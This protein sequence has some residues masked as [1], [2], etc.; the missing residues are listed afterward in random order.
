MSTWRSAR[1][2]FL[3]ALGIASFISIG[4]YGYGALRNHSA[5]YSYLIWNLLL[6]W[7]PLLFAILITRTLQ[8]KRWSSWQGIG[9]SI[10]WLVFLPNSFYMISDYIHL[11]EVKRVD[12]LFD[13]VMFTSFVYVGVILGF[14]SL[15]LVHI[16]LRKRLSARSSAIWIGATLL[17]SSAAIYVGRDLRWNSWDILT[18]PGGLLFDLSDRFM[19][20]ASY[21]QMLT[22]VISFFILLCSMYLLLWRAIR[23]VAQTK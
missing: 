11:L 7:L 19:H 3:L 2:Q 17:V 14:A 6:A 20:P 22:T 10:L 1:T 15:Y 23:L 18:N 4:L 13:T 21:P 5:G 8:N 12:V 9:Y 16:Q